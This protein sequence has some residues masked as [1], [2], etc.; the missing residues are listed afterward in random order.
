MLAMNRY[1]GTAKTRPASRIPR[2]FPYVDE[3]DEQDRQ[4]DRL[5]SERPGRPRSTASIPA[6]TETAT[7]SA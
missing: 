4:L 3:Q 5:G 7:V 6:A 2:R 1:V